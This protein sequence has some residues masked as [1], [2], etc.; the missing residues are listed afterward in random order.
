VLQAVQEA[1]GE[2]PVALPATGGSL[3][4]YVWTRILKQPSIIVPYANADED[5]H[6]PNENLSL[7]CFY[8]G[9]EITARV[10]YELSR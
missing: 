1:T 8:Q 4:D 6:A 3:P 10:I 2:K 9:L 7:D 5:N